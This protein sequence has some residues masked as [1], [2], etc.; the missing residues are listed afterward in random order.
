LDAYAKVVK[1]D[2][3]VSDDLHTALLNVFQ[4]LQADQSDSPEWHPTS[5]D[6]V[7]DLVRPS[8]YLL[9]YGQSRVFKEEVVG[10]E[11]AITKWAEKGAK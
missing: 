5:K 8:M 4:T 2:S 6:M 7:Q 11:D 1:S 3:L 10:V 9:V